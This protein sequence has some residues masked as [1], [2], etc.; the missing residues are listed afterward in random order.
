MT[1]PSGIGCNR[2]GAYTHYAVRV[3]DSFHTDKL[4]W[5]CPPCITEVGKDER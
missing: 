4:V 2:C 1:R 5:W 3:W